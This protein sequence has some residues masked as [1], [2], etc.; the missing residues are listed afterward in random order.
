MIRLATVH[1]QIPLRAIA[2]P[3]L[4]PCLARERPATSIGGDP[5]DH[6]AGEQR[7][8]ARGLGLALRHEYELERV[9]ARKDRRCF[10]IAGEARNR[11]RKDDPGR[12]V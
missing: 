1:F 12:Y 8:H 7:I 3:R 6:P 9:E 11:T 2:G 5:D 4:V 10:A